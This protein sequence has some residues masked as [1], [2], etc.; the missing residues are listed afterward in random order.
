MYVNRATL[1]LEYDNRTRNW[2]KNL[3]NV[4]P[5]QSGYDYETDRSSMIRWKKKF[6]IYED[7]F[8]LDGKSIYCI[9]EKNNASEVK[10]YIQGRVKYYNNIIKNNRFEEKKKKEKEEEE[11]KKSN[12]I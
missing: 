4:Y 5:S 9:V 1:L 10:E 11:R 8:L 12:K 2:S 7:I 3:N 6:S